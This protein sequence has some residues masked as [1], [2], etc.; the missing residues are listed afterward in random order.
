M[1]GIARAC[2]DSAGGLDN[3]GS[4][5]TVRVNGVPITVFGCSVRG[6]GNGMQKHGIV[7]HGK[8]IREEWHPFTIPDSSSHADHLQVNDEQMVMNLSPTEQYKNTYNINMRVM[9]W[10]DKKEWWQPINI[11]K[12]T[13]LSPNMFGL[14]WIKGSG[15]YWEL[16]RGTDVFAEGY[17]VGR[18]DNKEN[19]VLL[20]NPT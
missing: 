19:Y 18:N 12:E 6:H 7:H 20:L 4:N 15:V 10:N 8:V 16:F 14:K 3:I 17:V 5:T 9:R 13:K 1:P 2:V 11:N